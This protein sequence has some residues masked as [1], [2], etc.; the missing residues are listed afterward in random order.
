LGIAEVALLMVLGTAPNSPQPPLAVHVLVLGAS[1]LVGIAAAWAVD[2]WLNPKQSN[3]AGVMFRR[4]T[5][6]P[7]SP[8]GWLV[9]LLLLGLLV[10]P[11]L[12]LLPAL[13]PD[14]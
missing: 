11:L 12:T 13:L 1:L 9:A 8:G 6:L 4:A 3:S 14:S 7:I 10:G 5:F 2:R